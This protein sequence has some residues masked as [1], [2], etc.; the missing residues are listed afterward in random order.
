MGAVM[1]PAPAYDSR[2]DTYEH[3]AEVR[4]LLLN[5]A[6]DLLQRAHVHDASR[7]VPPEVGVFDLVTQELRDLTYGS[8]E[9]KAS[10]ARMGKALAHHY[11][12][13]SH[14]PEHHEAG[15][16]SMGLLDLL[17]ML[18]DWIAATRRHADGDIYR[19]IEINAE[20]FGYGDEIKRLLLNTVDT[21]MRGV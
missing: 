4:G 8:E 14:H 13:N 1:P 6:T 7:L 9:Y 12:A 10:L 15:I 19:S 16:R 17:E 3:I 20:R 18:C 21:P 11:E 2:P 5:A